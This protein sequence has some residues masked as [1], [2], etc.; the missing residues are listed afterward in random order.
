MKPKPIDFNRMKAIIVASISKQSFK[1]AEFVSNLENIIFRSEAIRLLDALQRFGYVRIESKD[2]RWVVHPQ[3]ITREMLINFFDQNRIRKPQKR[4]WTPEQKQRMAEIAKA[5]FQKKIIS[6]NDFTIEDL[7][8][9]ILRREKEQKKQQ[10]SSILASAG[11][12]VGDLLKLIEE[13][14]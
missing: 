3:F 13:V 7:R 10:L 6:L 9:E 8:N 2:Y 1:K 12:S 4:T 5:R 14:G 11:M